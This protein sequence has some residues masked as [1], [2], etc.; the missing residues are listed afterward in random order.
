MTHETSE[1]NVNQPGGITGI[2]VG[3]H[4]TTVPH[5]RDDRI[6]AM[7]FIAMLPLLLLMGCSSS[8]EEEW[9]SKLAQKCAAMGGH[10]YWDQQAHT[11]ECYR[12]PIGRMTKKLFKEAFNGPAPASRP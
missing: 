12:H 3:G 10:S 11:F 2:V 8:P 1:L 6:W 9:S 7:K 5:R 4:G